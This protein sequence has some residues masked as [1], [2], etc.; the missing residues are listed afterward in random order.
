MIQEILTYLAI[1]LSIVFI[2][3]KIWKIFFAKKK[4]KGCDSC[5]SCDDSLIK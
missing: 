2:L 5:S 3:R 4:T 1:V